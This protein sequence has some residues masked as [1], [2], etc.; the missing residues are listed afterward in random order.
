MC[1]LAE[2]GKLGVTGQGPRTACELACRTRRQ[3]PFHDQTGGMVAK[4]RLSA[5]RLRCGFLQPALDVA[6]E[7]AAGIR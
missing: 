5:F 7:Q 6:G 4:A 3:Y 2:D 1:R